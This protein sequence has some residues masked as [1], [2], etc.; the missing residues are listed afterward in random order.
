MTQP[1]KKKKQRQ[2]GKAKFQI[3]VCCFFESGWEIKIKHN[4]RVKKVF[5]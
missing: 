5:R 4:L 1:K 3:S 2:K